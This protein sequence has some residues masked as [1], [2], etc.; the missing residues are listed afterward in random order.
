MAGHEHEGGQNVMAKTC[1]KHVVLM[2]YVRNDKIIMVSRM[3]KKKRKGSHLF[4]LDRKIKGRRKE[5]SCFMFGLDE[6]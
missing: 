6:D 4:L 3:M 1:H 5:F 2:V